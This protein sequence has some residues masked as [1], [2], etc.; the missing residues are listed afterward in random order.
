M[1]RAQGDPESAE[2]LHRRA[3]AL[4]ERLLGPSHPDVA[5]SLN[6]LALLCSDSGR[7]AEA[8]PLLQRAAEI[9]EE[10]LEPGHAA[11]RAVLE[12]LRSVEA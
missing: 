10:R 8:L 2:E 11:R 5:A 3:L 9:V 1:R 6:N 7:P 4:R 12:N